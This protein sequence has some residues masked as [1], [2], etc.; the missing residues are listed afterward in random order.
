MTKNTTQKIDRFATQL[1]ECLGENLISLLLYGPGVRDE[2]AGSAEPTTLL[3]VR[4]ASPQALRSIQAT[5]AA[6]TKRGDPPPLIFSDGEWRS[7]A[8]VFPIE[9]EEMR[10]AHL[11]L[12]GANP[13][14]GVET[15][16]EDLRR[17]L[18]REVRGKLLQ[19]RTQF[20]AAA[21]D[22]KALSNLL[23]RSIVTFFILFRAVL[24][25]T[26]HTP[27]RRPREL[28]EKAAEV[29]GLEADAFEWVLAKISGAK[30]QNLKPYDPIGDR[31]VMQIEQLAHFVDSFEVTSIDSATDGGDNQ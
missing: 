15:D 28:V 9:I 18:E 5:I 4:D 16:S 6:W 14:D 10:E 24:R 2:S 23:T 1:A 11:L 13:L 7:S 17:E 30:P 27:P 29:A 26:G 25:L 20:A 21:S 12:K 22:G 3:V 31:Y 8:D 19:L